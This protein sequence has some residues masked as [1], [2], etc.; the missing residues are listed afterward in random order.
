MASCKRRGQQGDIIP[1]ISWKLVGSCTRIQ[2]MPKHK[3]VFPSKD[4]KPSRLCMWMDLGRFQARTSITQPTFACMQLWCPQFRQI[5]L[6]WQIGDLNNWCHEGLSTVQL[7][8]IV[9]VAMVTWLVLPW[10]WKLLNKSCLLR[11]HQ[12]IGCLTVCVCVEGGREGWEGDNKVT[13]YCSFT[14]SHSHHIGSG[15]VVT[16]SPRRWWSLVI[17]FHAGTRTWNLELCEVSR[18]HTHSSP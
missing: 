5:L 1:G 13:H 16:H 15:I 6:V 10:W 7:Q 4:K 2:I 3:L 12:N 8:V 17:R 11:W 18:T 9:S 14:Q